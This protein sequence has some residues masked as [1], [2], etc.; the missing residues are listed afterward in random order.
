MV[1][2][3]SK[4]SDGVDNLAGDADAPRASVETG[5]SRKISRRIGLPSGRAVVGALLVTVSIVGLFASYRQSQES[6]GSPYVVVAA[7]VAAGDVIEDHDLALRTL[8]LGELADRTLTSKSQAIGAVAV[9]T[10]LPGQLL[11]HSNIL[12]P[13]RRR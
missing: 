11:Q 3:V 6:T 10:F 13:V 5:P 12:L 1:T 7:T 4:G 8:D 9:Q 2:A